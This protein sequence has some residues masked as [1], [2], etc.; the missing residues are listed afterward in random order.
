MLYQ[1]GSALE[2]AEPV[3]FID[4]AAFSDAQRPFRRPTND[5]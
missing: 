2:K 1:T 5:H 4:S 3:I